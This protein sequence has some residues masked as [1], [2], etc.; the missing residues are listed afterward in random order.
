MRGSRFPVGGSAAAP[1]LFRAAST[2]REHCTALGN[3]PPHA[4]V[5][6]WSAEATAF[7]AVSYVIF[8]PSCVTSAQY[9]SSIFQYDRVA[10]RAVV[11]TRHTAASNHVRGFSNFA[12]S[13][14]FT[15][16]S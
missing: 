13:S 7:E 8:S 10:A 5:V 2:E 1:L 6:Q 16:L 15:R 9:S 14:E 12:P 3:K 4:D 11:A